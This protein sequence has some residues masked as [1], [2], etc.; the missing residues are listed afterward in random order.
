[1]SLSIVSTRSKIPCNASGLQQSHI[2]RFYVCLHCRYSNG[3]PSFITA[4]CLT[5][6]E[7]DGALQYD[8]L[9]FVISH[10]TC[11][12]QCATST[13]YWCAAS[14]WKAPWN[15]CLVE[16]LPISGFISFQYMNYYWVSL[17]PRSTWLW[18]KQFDNRQVSNII[19]SKAQH[20]KVYRT[21]LRLLLPNPLK[22]D[23]KS[24]MKMQF[25]QRR[26]AMLQLHLNDQ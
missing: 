1:M 2:I 6:S 19:R 25:E 14:K 17:R 21:V 24:W 10:A 5:S 8:T 16:Y 26:Q 13:A 18:S 4:H 15:I 7:L 23:V 12:S 22:P 3:N 9:S 11:V 20:L